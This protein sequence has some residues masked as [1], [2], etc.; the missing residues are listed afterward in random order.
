MIKHVIHDPSK[1]RQQIEEQGKLL[2]K[3]NFQLGFDDTL[4]ESEYSKVAAE[5]QRTKNNAASG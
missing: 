3:H 1:G 2:R 5:A 4:N